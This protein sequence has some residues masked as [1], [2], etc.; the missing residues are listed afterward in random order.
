MIADGYTNYRRSNRGVMKST[1]FLATDGNT[2]IVAAK[3]GRIL[4]I[5]KLRVTIKTTAAQAMTFQDTGGLY[6]CKI[7]ASPTVDSIITFDF[8]PKGIPLT[9]SLGLQQA[10][11]AGNAGHVEVEGYYSRD[12]GLL[13]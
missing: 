8:G 4:W 1:T 13:Q 12:G 9:I 11:T 10:M 6:V 7:A 2:T 3:T 5:Q